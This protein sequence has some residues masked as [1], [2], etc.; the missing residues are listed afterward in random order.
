MGEN[1]PVIQLNTE[2]QYANIKDTL[3]TLFNNI[4]PEGQV[5]VMKELMKTLSKEQSKKII[6]YVQNIKKRITKQTVDILNTSLTTATSIQPVPSIYAIN[7][8]KVKLR[9]KNILQGAYVCI[10][11]RT[12]QMPLI[13]ILNVILVK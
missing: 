10:V 1:L 3:L 4:E 8:S 11:L 6:N 2:Q 5:Y 9:N 12:Y 13:C 7:I